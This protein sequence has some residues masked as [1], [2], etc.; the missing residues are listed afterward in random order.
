MGEPIILLLRACATNAL[1]EVVKVPS[2]LMQF[3][4]YLTLCREAVAEH[5]CQGRS[6]LQPFFLGALRCPVRQNFQGPPQLICSVPVLHDLAQFLARPR[7]HLVLLHLALVQRRLRCPIASFPATGITGR[8]GRSFQSRRALP[9]LTQKTPTPRENFQGFD[10][11]TVD[12]FWRRRVGLS[13]LH[14]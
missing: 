5:H 10:Y 6:G 14:L 2:G 3:I 12:F 9:L 7:Y 8:R 1:Y 4:L 11:R 13:L